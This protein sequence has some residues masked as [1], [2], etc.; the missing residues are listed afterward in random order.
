MFVHLIRSKYPSKE[1]ELRVFLNFGMSFSLI[2]HAESKAFSGKRQLSL[3]PHAFITAF[4]TVLSVLVSI[5]SAHC[6]KHGYPDERTRKSAE[7]RNKKP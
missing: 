4:T 3:S 5:S 6:R 2:L 7:K 1:S